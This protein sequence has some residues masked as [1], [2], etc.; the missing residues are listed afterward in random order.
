MYNTGKDMS[1]SAITAQRESSP[2][3]RLFG[4]KERVPLHP[5]VQVRDN[6]R[7]PM[8]EKRGWNRAKKIFAPR[9]QM[10]SGIFI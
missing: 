4:K 1:V 8:S 7:F 9:R 6:L 5:A 2:A 3:A 10:P